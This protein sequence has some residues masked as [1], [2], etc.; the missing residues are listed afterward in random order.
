MNTLLPI[1]LPRWCIGW[2]TRLSVA[3]TRLQEAC[4]VS[5]TAFRPSDWLE[6]QTGG[7]ASYDSVGI[8]IPR[9]RCNRSIFASCGISDEWTLVASIESALRTIGLDTEI[10]K[11]LACPGSTYEIRITGVRF[12]TSAEIFI[13]PSL[14]QPR[15]TLFRIMLT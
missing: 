2:P 15:D 4:R 6:F 13:R 8:R 1:R 5:L 10:P 14:T 11:A 7:I 3:R 12:V 9:F